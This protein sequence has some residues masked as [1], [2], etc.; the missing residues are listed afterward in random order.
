MTSDA[1]ETRSQVPGPD[2]TE[3]P[4]SQHGETKVDP[5][6]DTSYGTGAALE[7]VDE[8]EVDDDGEV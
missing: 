4:G 7:N 3:A 8:D 6:A 5:D 1:G 2:D